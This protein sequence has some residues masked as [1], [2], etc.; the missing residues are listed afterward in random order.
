[1]NV[2]RS[3]PHA[4]TFQALRP[5][6]IGLAYRML[7][8]LARAED[9]MQ[10]AWLRW[11]Q[12]AAEID[13]PRAYLSTIVTRLCLNELGSAR[14]RREHSRGD[15]LPEPI[16]FAAHS[17][18]SLEQ[19]ERISM[20]FLVLLQRLS[21]T[22]RAVF[23]LHEVFDF[24][25]AQIA[26]LVG[27]SVPSCRKLLE[28]A[29][30]A[31]ALGRKTLTTSREEHQRLLRAFVAA[32]MAGNLDELVSLLAKDAELVSDGGATGRVVEGVRN[33][34]LPIRGAANVAKFL[35]RTSTRA[36]AVFQFR[37]RD[38]NGQPAVVFY[39]DGAPF[40]ALLLA[41]AD[42]QIQYVFF[43]ADPERLG[44]VGTLDA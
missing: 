8:D 29:R 37:E 32:A 39:R 20:A 41:I 17:G 22:E 24:E 38:L 18:E 23:L 25:H 6:M 4:E 36:A 9:I 40:A 43:H 14:A 11:Q 31:V 3:A 35:A 30:H 44:H 26:E 27:R 33:P 10:D 21:P 16:D 7:G 5:E 28:R 15:R 2:N 1:M 42:N 12:S 19:S 34:R 13:S